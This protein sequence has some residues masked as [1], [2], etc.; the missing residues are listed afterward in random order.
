MKRSVKSHRIVEKKEERVK[1]I[2]L[3]QQM[4]LME[5]SGYRK[6]NS[7][8]RRKNKILE[9]ADLGMSSELM[10]VIG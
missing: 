6:W 9:V 7:W 5:I 3:E 1:A 4:K 10:E 8:D 2:G